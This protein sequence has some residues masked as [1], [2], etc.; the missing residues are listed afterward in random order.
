MR[1]VI[2]H[3]K[4]RYGRDAASHCTLQKALRGPGHSRKC[5]GAFLLLFQHLKKKISHTAEDESP[6]SEKTSVYLLTYPKKRCGVWDTVAVVVA[7]DFFASF[8]FA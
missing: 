3:S 8:F 5:P 6:Y 1:Q 7:G 4:K 2:A